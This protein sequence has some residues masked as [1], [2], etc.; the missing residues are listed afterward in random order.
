MLLSR[1]LLAAGAA[2]FL[3]IAG[4]QNL[5]TEGRSCAD[6]A[7]LA[8]AP[9]DT[10][11]LFAPGVVNRGLAC[12]D[13][14]V[15][16]G[17]DEIWWCEQ[18]GNFRHSV[19]TVARRVDGAWREP[20]TAPFSGDPRWRDI[21]P[22]FSLDGRTLYFA[23]D[24]PADGDGPAVEH[25]AIWRVRRT[26][27]GWDAPERL[28]DAVND[29]ATFFPSPTADGTLYL[30]RDLE[31]GV[32]AVFRSRLVD[33]QYAPAE[34]LPAQVNAGR[35]RFNAVVDPDERFLI[36]PIFGLPDSR[37]GVDYYLVARNA[38]DTWQEPVNLGDAV[39]SEARQ[40]WSAA[41]APDGGALY[42]MSDRAL[43]PAADA[44]PLTRARLRELHN[45]P[46]TG[47][48]GIWW[49]DARAV[50]VLRPFLREPA[51]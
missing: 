37:G 20:E 29:G 35:T 16:P 49:I 26:A 41:L 12:R 30:T 43:P 22:A 21:E 19:L 9:A 40:E 23:S 1:P 50:E 47:Q 14:A 7:V 31:G 33:G 51:S 42:F 10:A 34:M 15:A 5:E 13:V 36:V 4:C 18:V 24:R 45:A 48:S 39:N 17:G 28:P 6:P 27:Q 32:S 3:L 38:D 25:T 2:A 11:A 44:A 8:A 46:G